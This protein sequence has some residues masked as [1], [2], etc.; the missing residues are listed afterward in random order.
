MLMNLD[1]GILGLEFEATQVTNVSERMMMLTNE[2]S[3]AAEEKISVLKNAIG[4]KPLGLTEKYDSPNVWMTLA[5][6]A[7]HLDDISYVTEDKVSKL[8]QATKA[9]TNI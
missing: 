3:T 1:K 9:D 6:I 7:T 8:L 4:G 2:S 5:T